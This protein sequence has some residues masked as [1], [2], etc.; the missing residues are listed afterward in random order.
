[1]ASAS[2]L[3]FRRSRWRIVASGF[4]LVA[5]HQVVLSGVLL[6]RRGL[7]IP[8]L[9]FPPALDLR[10]ELFLLLL[11]HGKEVVQIVAARFAYPMPHRADFLYGDVLFQMVVSR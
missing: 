5:Q 2:A 1:M 7:L 6:R 10:L 11:E 3:K 9:H 8:P 4:G